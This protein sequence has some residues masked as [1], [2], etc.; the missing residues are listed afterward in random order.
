MIL[1]FSATGNSRF[2]AEYL[3]GVLNDEVVSINDILKYQKVTTF[4]SE[5]PFVF[6][7]PI[8][9]WRLP[10][11]VEQL[12]KEVSFI[13]N[14]NVYVIATIGQ[15]A[16]NASKYCE[17]ILEKKGLS[18]RGF[19]S[20]IMPDSYVVSERMVTKQEA[21]QQIQKIISDIHKFSTCIKNEQDI[22]V[23]HTITMKD[24]FLSSVGY[25]GFH[26]FM[27]HSNS[28]TVLDTCI[29]CG[30]CV[31]RCPTNNIVLDANGITF[32]NDC[33]FC[34]SCLH[35]CPQQALEYK[36]KIKEH[37]QYICPTMDEIMGK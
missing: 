11:H 10:Y 32:K 20:V 30:I 36:G 29:H 8:Y 14:S 17:S 4:H 6:V 9:A 22:K 15:H 35:H 1:Y 24:R 13:G 2:V 21:I 12:I 28:F 27:E 23:Q 26:H 19:E 16:G 5:K 3:A 25:W 33:M 31:S 37:G 7:V 18:Y 34:L